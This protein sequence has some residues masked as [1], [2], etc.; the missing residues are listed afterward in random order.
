M[1][2]FKFRAWDKNKRVFTDL[3][4][5]IALDGV[6]RI[7]DVVQPTLLCRSS[8]W[9]VEQFTGL[10]DKN[11]KEIYEGDIVKAREGNGDW[12]IAE[13]YWD[14]PEFRLRHTPTGFDG[15]FSIFANL[16][17][18]VDDESA[19]FIVIGNIHENPEL[20]K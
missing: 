11:G 20:L 8:D 14:T 13:V 9:V 16:H 6:I 18:D 12:R 4:F 3:D 5:T 7:L 15:W 10:R 17:R 19:L 2:E 1:R